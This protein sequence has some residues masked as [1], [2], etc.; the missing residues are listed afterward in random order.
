MRGGGGGNIQEMLERLPTIA[1]ADVKVGDTII[2]S[3]TRGA[4]PARLTAITLVSGADAFLNM[5]AARQ[6]TQTGGQ[7]APNPAGGLGSGIQFGI[8]LP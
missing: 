5:I 7:T 3:S 2:V 6:Q 4:D 8:G 1:L